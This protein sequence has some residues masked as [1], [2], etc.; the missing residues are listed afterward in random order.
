MSGID[1]LAWLQ[2]QTFSSGARIAP[3][4]DGYMD[5]KSFYIENLSI[6]DYRALRVI[7]ITDSLLIRASCKTSKIEHKHCSE[8]A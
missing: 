3:E 5:V 8:S 7:M 2:V 1:V 6:L 4:E